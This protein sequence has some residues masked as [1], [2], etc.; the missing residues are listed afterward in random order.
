MHSLKSECCQ[1][2]VD[3]YSG[4]GAIDAAQG[5]MGIDVKERRREYDAY[6]FYSYYSLYNLIYYSE[7]H[8]IYS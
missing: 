2:F 3:S 7:I 8:S 6:M 1:G 5:K 4:L